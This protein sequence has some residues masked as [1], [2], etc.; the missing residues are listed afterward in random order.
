LSPIEDGFYSLETEHAKRT[1]PRPKFLFGWGDYRNKGHNP[2][3]LSWV[4]VP[5]KMVSGTQKLGM[6]EEQ[7]QD[8]SC[9]FWWGDYGNRSHKPEKLSWVRVP[10]RMVFVAF[11]VKSIEW[12]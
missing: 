7:H 10:M 4:Q 11:K 2:R 12:S 6:L 5:V 1:E 3:N 8:Q 9:L